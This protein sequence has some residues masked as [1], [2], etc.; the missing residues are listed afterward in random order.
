MKEEWKVCTVR[1]GHIL[2]GKPESPY[3][4]P[5]AL[6]MEEIVAKDS[7][8]KGYSPVIPNARDM[9]LDRNSVDDDAKVI[10]I[11]VYKEDREDVDNFIWG[12]DKTYPDDTEHL[13]SP[14]VFRYRIK[15]SK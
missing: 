11:E 13:P 10:P 7:K 12:F 14:M 2:D 5:I 6:A 9:R 1:T 3:C 15:R 4:C 8:Y